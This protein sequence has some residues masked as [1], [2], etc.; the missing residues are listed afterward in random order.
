[1]AEW[2][3]SYRVC[4]ES[5]E[6]KNNLEDLGVDG[7]MIMNWVFVKWDEKAWNGLIWRSTG[8]GGELL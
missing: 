8:T 3:R 1:M 7:N 5:P 2:R 6:E 4:V